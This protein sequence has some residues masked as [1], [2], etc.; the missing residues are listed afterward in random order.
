MTSTARAKHFVSAAELAALVSSSAPPVVLD[1]RNE[2]GVPDGRPEYEMGHVP[3]ALYVDLLTELVG[4]V[5]GHKGAGPL[6]GI[7]DLQARARS[8][9]I[10]NGGPVVV[11]DNV[12]GTKAGRA[13]FVLRWAG[14]ESVRLLDGATL[15]GC[16]AATP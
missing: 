4:T 16:R 15:H 3:G 1:V 6:P 7:T 14:I 12:F 11:Y 10:D 9:G 8:W 2:N 13:W 5:D